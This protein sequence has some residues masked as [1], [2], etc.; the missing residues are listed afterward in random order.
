MDNK[1]AKEEMALEMIARACDLMDWEILLPDE[2]SG[3]H[4]YWMVI[5]TKEGIE[6]AVRHINGENN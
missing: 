1:R 5:G 4:V 6:S 2:G 3:E